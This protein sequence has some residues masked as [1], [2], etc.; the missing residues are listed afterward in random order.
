VVAINRRIP[1]L[2]VL[3]FLFVLSASAPRAW[4]LASGNIPLDSPAYPYLEKLSGF[5]L[6]SSDVRGLKPYSKAEA[7][8][9]LAEAEQ[10]LSRL[11]AESS[12]LA[13]GIVDRLHEL[14]PREIALRKNQAGGELLDYSLMSAARLRYVYLDGQPRSY[15]RQVFVRGG[16]SA[17]GFI[18]GKLRPDNNAGIVSQS[19]T[20][21]TPLLENNEGVIYRSGSNGELR[22]VTEGF[23]A[24]KVS[25]L[26]E[27]I[28]TV[29]PDESRLAFQKGYLKLGG[30]GLELEVGRDA[31]WFGPG[32]RGALTLTSNAAN[33][34]LIKLSSPEPLDVGWVKEYLG[35]VKYALVFSR[36]DETGSGASLRKP[37]FIGIK[38]AVQPKPWFEIGWNFVRQE[39][40]PGFSGSSTLQDTIFGGGTT[41]HNNTIAGIDLRFRLPWLRN[42]ELYGE[43]AGEDSAAFWPIVESYVAGFYIPRLTAGGKDDLRFEF[44]YGNPMLYTDF[45]FPTGYVYKG[46]T[47]GHSQGGSALE[48]FTRYSH[49]FSAR[50]NVALEYFHTDRGREGRVDS[51]QTEDKHAVRAFWTFPLFDRFD[52]GVMYGWERI[53]NFN[54]VGGAKQTNQLLRADLSYRY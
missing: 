49:W 37:W 20:E 26:I 42:A 54:L 5:G 9:L 52:A 17:F 41:N 23:I 4:A 40:G 32:Y 50:N 30:G 27:P 25:V 51:Q 2:S 39:G 21:G 12:V 43:Y 48:F 45:K 1:L 18:G 15:A 24:D 28:V 29:E 7:A 13:Q 47:S 44:F 31:N 36:F 8:R 19:G 33:F 53:D 46:M 16:Q 3:L 22:W 10:G 14:L 34:D 38:L 6:L 11:E 35:N